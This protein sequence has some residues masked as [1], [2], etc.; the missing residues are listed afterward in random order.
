MLLLGLALVVTGCSQGNAPGGDLGV[1]VS[2]K[3]LTVVVGQ[4]ADDTV[5]ITA[6]GYSGAVNL[7]LV[8]A[9]GQ[10]AVG[11]SVSPS[12]VSVAAGT[13]GTQQLLVVAA[14]SDHAATTTFELRA[15]GGNLTGSAA[16][17]LQLLYSG[18]FQTAVNYPAG[19][20]PYSVAVGD[21]DGDGKPD[22]AVAD[23]GG[24]L[25]VSARS[26]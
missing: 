12:S 2:P 22:L 26:A 3:T 8:N 19:T 11:L 15:T 20:N 1:A 21:F 9:T 13:S 5:T 16:L 24:G 18:T 6:S 17:T 4:S 25:G 7:S 10:A 23:H 14:E